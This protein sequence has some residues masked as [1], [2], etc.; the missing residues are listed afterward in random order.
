VADSS[1]QLIKNLRAKYPQYRK[2]D[3]NTLVDALHSKYPQYRQH[4]AT[5]KRLPKGMIE[6]GTINLNGRPVIE[7]DD[8]SHSTEFS[9]SFYDDKNGKGEVLVP[10]IVNGKFLTP[11]GKKPAEGTR[12]AN[13][14]YQAT[15]EEEAMWQ[16]AKNHYYATGEHMGIFS[17]SDDADAYAQ[18]VHERDAAPL[19]DTK[20]YVLD[21]QK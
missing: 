12:D 19:A 5:A 3:H 9:F 20:M 1:E 21:Q 18:Q 13:G 11:D 8:G 4:L 16:R 15:W 6:R 2:I 7:N 17:N 10:T 14:K